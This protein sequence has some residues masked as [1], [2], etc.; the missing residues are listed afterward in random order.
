M[1]T[2]ATTVAM[3]AALCTQL[4]HQKQTASEICT[5]TYLCLSVYSMYGHPTAS[6]H[7]RFTAVPSYQQMQTSRGARL[8]GSVD[9]DAAVARCNDLAQQRLV[10]HRVVRHREHLRM[11]Q[12]YRE[13]LRIRRPAA[14]LC[15]TYTWLLVET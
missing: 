6:K 9:R 7:G 14:W 1:L 8:P 3:A 5:P 11:Q 10:Q 15:M 12:L 13:R 2:G 4:E